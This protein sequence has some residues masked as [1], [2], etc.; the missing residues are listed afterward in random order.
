MP[1]DSSRGRCA[2]ERRQSDQL[3]GFR[4]RARAGIA[5][6]AGKVQRQA[7]LA[8]TRA[9]GISVG[10]WN[11]KAMRRP[12]CAAG[13]AGEPHHAQRAGARL[14]AG[15]AI[16]L[17]SVLLPQPDGPSSVTNSPACTARS[18]GA[19]ARVPFG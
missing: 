14:E 17:S 6:R 13:G 9:H 18:T 10:A 19:S 8:S 11:T 7:T 5:R 1:P 12:S 15:L 16:R 4:C 2:G 3:Q